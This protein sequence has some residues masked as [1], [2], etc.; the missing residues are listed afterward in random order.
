[1]KILHFDGYLA[2]DAET[3]QT[4]KG[5]A[6][7]SFR[8]GN[9]SFVKGENK[10]EWIDVA[11]F[12]ANDI[13]NKAQYLKKGSHVF[14]SGTPDT[15]VNPGKDGRL[16]VNTSVLADRIDFINSGKKD[17]DGEG[18]ETAANEPQISV[19]GSETNYNDVEKQLAQKVEAPAPAPAAA[20][21]T[22]GGDDE[23]ALPF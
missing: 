4:A 13:T 15:T 12:N 21:A 1:M 18:G 11:S 8:V 6:F 7:L 19:S 5:V 22:S 20:P 9:T 2:K 23:E 17:K 14:I 10:T 16:Y 3:K